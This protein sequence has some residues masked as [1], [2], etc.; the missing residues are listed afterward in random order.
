MPDAYKNRIAEKGASL[1]GGQKQRLSIA[2][3]VLKKPEILILDD[4]TSA[5]DLSTESKLRAQLDE[6]MDNTT[7][8]II[9]QRIASVKTC[10]RI[11]V[12]DHGR[13]CGCDTHENLLE[14][15]SVYKDIYDS[16]VK[17]TGGEI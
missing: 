1:S 4:S 17:T 7:L 15:C 14:S 11:A 10:D 12:L 6:Q 16:Q 8:I 3:A 9:A 13:L 5:L 2:R